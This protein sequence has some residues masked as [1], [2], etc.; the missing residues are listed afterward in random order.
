MPLFSDPACRVEDPF[1][2]RA[3]ELAERGRGSVS[4]NPMVGCVVVRDGEVVGEG[5]HEHAG[6]PHAEVVALAQAGTRAPGAHV[7]VTLE[8]CNHIGRTPPCAPALIDAGVSEVTIGMRDPNHAVSG[9]GAERLAQSGVSVNWA[10][11][12]GPFEAQNEAWLLRLRAGRPWVRVKVALTLDGR[13]TLVEGRRSQLTGQGGRTTTMRLRSAATA[14]AVGATTLA[15]DDPSLTVRDD[16]DVPFARQPQRLVLCR[17]TVPKP[18]AT[19]FSDG[20]GVASVVVGDTSAAES[21]ARLV[22]A[23]VRVLTYPDGEHARGMLTA[24]AGAGIDDVLV[25]A[26][27][28]LFSTLWRDRL[29][30][31]LV[32]ITA[33]GTAGSAAPPLYLGSPESDDTDLNAWLL[34]TEAGVAGDDAVTVWRPRL[35]DGP[36]GFEKGSA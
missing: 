1:L 10:K 15:I 16:G 12:P 11:D 30:D 21:R 33:G 25:E 23:G 31:E 28:G 7:C 35:P 29:I 9:G 26:G 2:R 24:V 27:P 20:C 19:V 32:I 4:P 13:P 6:G 5:Y 22:D 18:T 36:S 17:T 8:P 34:A 14:V 3:F